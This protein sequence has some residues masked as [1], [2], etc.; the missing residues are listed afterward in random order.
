MS[1]RA[2]SNIN[3]IHRHAYGANIGWLDFRGDG[4]HGAVL[5]QM[6]A[7]GHVWSANCGWISLGNT[8]TNGWQYSN[9]SGNDW[10]V[11]HDGI[12]NLRGYAYGANIGWIQFESSGH[13]QVDLTSGALSGYVYGANVGWISLS[14]SFAFVQT[15][16][17]SEGPDSDQ[18]GIPDPWEW[19][20]ALDLAPLG[21]NADWDVDGQTDHEEYL[22]DTDPF[23]PLSRLEII[24]LARTGTTDRVTWT[25][26]LTRHYQLEKATELTNT[27]AW[28][29]SGLGGGRTH[30]QR[31][32][33]VHQRG[34]I[35][36]GEGPHSVGPVNRYRPPRR[37]I[38]PLERLQ[39]LHRTRRPI[40]VLER[41]NR[42]V[43]DVVLPFPQT[44]GQL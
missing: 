1:S 12:G 41:E 10:G 18:D 9:A 28:A 25:V 22:A 20:V 33:I 26:R 43:Q 24:A 16:S 8:P 32:H 31:R 17:L 35:L 7:T 29:D 42:I 23:D 13:P 39:G 6:Y 11:N 14:N 30:L 4:A 5:G 44:S 21:T 27:A 3:G 2:D 36:S 34:S 19:K 40:R 38:G 15:D 37:G